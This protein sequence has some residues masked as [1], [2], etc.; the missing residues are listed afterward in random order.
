MKNDSSFRTLPLIPYI[1]KL[2]L[3]ERKNQEVN[4]R[5]CKEFYNKRYNDYIFVNAVGNLL[6]PG[7]L[8]QHFQVILKRHNLKHIR[9]H[10]LRHSCASVLLAHGISMKHIQEW[11]GHST[12]QITA[13]TYSHLDFR[14]KMSSARAITE[15]LAMTNP[16]ASQPKLLN[17]E[18]LTE[19]ELDRELERLQQEKMLRNRKKEQDFEM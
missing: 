5:T 17:Y 4:R 7:Y 10:D 11:L 15:N 18:A 12:F 2:L 1:E 6:K 9:F 3:Q 16:Y 14:S 8:T 13:D 19:D